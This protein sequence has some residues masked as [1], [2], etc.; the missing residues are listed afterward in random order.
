MMP[1]RHGMLTLECQQQGCPAHGQLWRFVP[2]MPLEGLVTWPNYRCLAC[3]TE[4]AAVEL[5]AW[6]T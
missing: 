6:G 4:P 1:I 3:G 5:P 2:D